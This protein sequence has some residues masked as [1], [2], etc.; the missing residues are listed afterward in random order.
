[1]KRYIYLFLMMLLLLWSGNIKGQGT[2]YT[3]TLQTLPAGTGSVTGAGNYT[4]GAVINVRTS[5]SYTYFKFKSWNEGN[6]VVSTSANFNF[7][8]PERA[9]ILTAIY[10]FDPNNPAD[11]DALYNVTLQVYPPGAGSV[12]GAGQYAVGANRNIYAYNATGFKFQAWKEGETTV[13]TSLSFSYQIPA[14][15]VT[16]TAVFTYDPNNPAEPVT[17]DIKTK[18][19]LFLEAQPKAG[20]SFNISNGNKYEE[21]QV[22][23]LY[24]Y[25]NTGF[26]FLEWRDGQTVISSNQGFNY[27]MGGSNK[28]LTAIYNYDP[29]NPSEPNTPTEIEHGLIALTQF[30]DRGQTIV[31]PVYLLNHNIN[32]R[33]VEF[34]IVFPADVAVD[35]ANAILSSRVNGH[36]VTASAKGNNTFHYIVQNS[37]PTDFSGSNGVLIS[38]PLTLPVTWASDSVYPVKINS[39]VLGSPAGPVN[40]TAHQGALGITGALNSGVIAGFYSNKFLNRVSFINLSSESATNYS[41]SFGDGT[42]STEK[43]PLHVYTSGGSYNV[44]LIASN[45]SLRDTVFHTVEI[46]PENTWTLSG[47]FSLNKH[48]QELKNFTSVKELFLL[49]SKVNID[50]NVTIDVEAG[51]T[52]EW[53]MTAGE[54]SQFTLILNKLAA[55]NNKL[56]FNKDGDST[57]PAIHFTGALSTAGYSAL[58]RLGQRMETNGVEIKILGQTVNLQR[59]YSYLPQQICTGTNSGQVNFTDISPA[60]S[61]SWNLA[62]SPAAIT[63]Y[64]VSG[65]GNLPEMSLSNSS[66]KTDSLRYKISIMYT[67]PSSAPVELYSWEY[68][69]F[70]LPALQG[71]L[72]FLS[73]AEGAVLSNSTVTLSWNSITNATYDLY[74][75]EEYEDEPLTPSV[76]QIKATSYQSSTLFRY[77]KTYLCKVVAYNECSRIESQT[78][79][80]TVRMLP[81]LHVTSINLPENI[82]A[83]SE[84]DISYTIKNDGRGATLSGENWNE[85]IGIVQNMQSPSTIFW[86]AERGNQSALDAGDSYTSTVKVTLP[87]RL[88]GDAC[89]VVTC[90]MGNILSI[91][92]TPVGNV[93]PVPYTPN[94]SGIPYPYLKAQTPINNSRMPEDGETNTITDNFFYTQVEI[95]LQKLPDLTVTAIVL[96]VNAVETSS[97][98]VKATIRNSGEAELDGKTWNDGIYYAKTSDFNPATAVLAAVVQ[99]NNTLEPGESYE[100]T[101]TVVAPVDSLTN[102]Y[103]FVAA[104]ISDDVFESNNSN[105]RLV[106]DPILILPYMMNVDDYQQLKLIFDGFAGVQWNNKWNTASSRVGNY[107]PGVSFDNGRVTGISLTGNNLAGELS[108]VFLKFPFLTSLNLNNNQLTGGLTALLAGTNLPVNLAT[109]NIGKNFLTGTI[110]ATIVKLTGLTNLDLSYN[111]LTDME[112]ALPATITGLNLQYQTFEKDSTVLSKQTGLDV[113]LIALYDHTAKSFNSFPNFSLLTPSNQR[114]FGYVPENGSQYKWDVS[115]VNE[116]N[117][118]WRYDSGTEFILV[119]ETGLTKGSTFAFKIKFDAGDSNLD[120]TVDILDVQQILNYIFKI[121]VSAFNFAAADT[122]KDNNVTVQDL[123][124]TIQIIL[125]DGAGKSPLFR[126]MPVDE[127]KNTLY[128]KD[129][130]LVLFTEEAV[131]SMDIRFEGTLEKDFSQT[132]NDSKFQFVFKDSETGTR[133]IIVSMTRDVIPPGRTVIAEISSGD[134]TLIDV[135]ASNLDAQPVPV[136]IST[137][138]TGNF[139]PEISEIRVF[140][141]DRTVCLDLPRKAEQIVA[142]LYTFSGIAVE[143]QFFTDLPSGKHILF[144]NVNYNNYNYILNLVAV[145]E[146]RNISKNIKL[147]LKK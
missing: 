113:P 85:R 140:T 49:L 7:T 133:L 130:Q 22:V 50:G 76:S 97:F 145:S 60:F 24:A 46:S 13:S 88:I 58:I 134:A 4:A 44:R 57:V 142:T 56:I 30:G 10:E 65:T 32:I 52:F 143:R 18:S 124:K 67:P 62:A 100:A 34:D 38:I 26:K 21:G 102:Y 55:G 72:N 47:T 69:I 91:D 120:N 31:F 75:Y 123:V 136:R 92:W 122:Y 35:Y 93:V 20:G 77:G 111:R 80:F 25:T 19:S 43:N 39:V 128:I 83:G 117:F 29:N 129:G 116:R 70:V 11:P 2:Q 42:A 17:P 40:S 71:Q 41:W 115:P 89:I 104:D 5:G 127:T 103:Y 108:G 105:N 68:K 28:T 118:V 114:I 51:E 121:Q 132:L 126:S 131:A 37:T 119:Q 36:T 61:Y 9:C 3:L 84:I 125:D 96:P 66:N 109:L 53:N 78:L 99:A 144:S 59:I 16:L 101:F 95:N 79:T 87:E 147:L 146:G 33:S 107:W 82:I 138:V 110:P 12:S 106:S 139:H 74:V 98:N 86:L 63:G 8:M 23:Y 90:N 135:T 14:R 141:E 112:Q 45:A 6:T 64:T 48:K 1:M 15:N 94:V 81:N 54:D 27:T 137:D 73:P